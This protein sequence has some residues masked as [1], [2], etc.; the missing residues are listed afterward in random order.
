VEAGV[1][2]VDSETR[3]RNARERHYRSVVLPTLVD[4]DDGD[5][6]DDDRQKLALSMIRAIFADVDRAIRNRTFGSHAE[7]AEVRV[8]GEIDERGWKELGRIMVRTAVVTGLEL[9][10]SRRQF[11]AGG[12]THSSLSAGCPAPKGFPCAVFPL[13]RTSFAFARR[14]VSVPLDRSC[15]AR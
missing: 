4:Q 14:T 6:T 7:H 15:G 12:E 9:Q 10:L 8:P 3:K 11:R 1:V 2:V 5:W 13:L